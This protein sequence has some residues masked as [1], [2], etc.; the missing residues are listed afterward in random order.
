MYLPYL[1]GKKTSVVLFCR[2]R[3]HLDKICACLY[4]FHDVCIWGC[5][6]WSEIFFCAWCVLAGHDNSRNLLSVHM[7]AGIMMSWAESLL[8]TC[9]RRWWRST[10]STF[11]EIAIGHDDIS[12][13]ITT[14]RHQGMLSALSN[15]GICQHGLNTKA[16]FQSNLRIF[17]CAKSIFIGDADDHKDVPSQND[18]L[19]LFFPKSS[20]MSHVPGRCLHDWEFL[21]HGTRAWRRTSKSVCFKLWRLD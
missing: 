12:I 10:Q 3:G 8:L 19:A 5:K 6:P 7:D 1:Q 13:W 16:Y 9:V 15:S 4:H 21:L 2:T 18:L 11:G 17:P 14:I 20:D